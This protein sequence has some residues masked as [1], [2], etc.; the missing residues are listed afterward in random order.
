MKRAWSIVFVLALVAAAVYA[1]TPGEG[2]IPLFANLTLTEGAGSCAT[3]Q[4][5][6]D[7]AEVPVWIP[8]A[9]CNAT[10]SCGS[11]TVSCSGTTTCSSVDRACPTEQGRVTCNGVTTWC[12][13]PCCGS[14]DFCCKCSATSSCFDCCRC[15]GGAQ[16]YCVDLCDS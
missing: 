5:G 16:H 11:G 3:A 13:T 10:A 8:M 15:S 14:S 2:S 9:S 12:S 4:S 6:A 7:L 1:Q